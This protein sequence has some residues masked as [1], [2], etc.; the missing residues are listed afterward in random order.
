MQVPFD[1]MIRHGERLVL[2]ARPGGNQPG[3]LL[4][5]FTLIRTVLNAQAEI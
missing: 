5:P 1:S 3:L 2:G 4:T